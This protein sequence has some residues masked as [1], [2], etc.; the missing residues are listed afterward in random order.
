[1][2][3]IGLLDL[4]SVYQRPLVLLALIWGGGVFLLAYWLQTALQEN[5]NLSSE[6]IALGLAPLSEE[7]LKGFLLV[8]LAQNGRLSYSTEGTTYGFAIGTGFA[9]LENGLYITTHPEAALSVALS[10]VLSVSVMHASTT[11][12]L[13]TIV[14]TY[15]L[16]PTRLQRRWA[17]LA[18]ALASLIHGGFNFLALRLSG[19][20]VLLAGMGVG[21]LSLAAVVWQIRASVRLDSRSIRRELLDSL[22]SGELAAT[23]QPRHLA[24]HLEAEAPALG[25]E[26]MQRVYQYARLQAQRGLLRQSLLTAQHGTARPLLERDLARV[27]QQLDVLRRGMGLYTWLWLRSV[28]PS[29]EA[30]LWSHLAR[31]VEQE[32]PLLA[33][34]LKLNDRRARLSDQEVAE[35]VALLK[36]TAFFYPLGPE[37][38]EDVAILLHEAHY[39]LDELILG[40]GQVAEELYC[41]AAGNV[42][43]SLL[44][45]DGHQTILAAYERG[46]CFGDLSLIDRRPIEEAYRCLNAVRLYTFARADFLTLVYGKPQV[47]LEVMRKLVEDIRQQAALLAWFHQTSKPKIT[48]TISASPK[49]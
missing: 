35:R 16:Q 37:D 6:Q 31:E 11:A 33:L 7:A 29:S 18:W 4:Y 27:E 5:Q 21:L 34:L 30:E 20:A 2:Y 19:Q 47:G 26:R 38:L 17:L 24:D 49:N 10:R 40:P 1:L 43:A 48:A 13:G 14:G 22:S 42:V 23:L 32:Q 12:L 45:A 3:T 46:D 15:A 36:T 28:L 41:V 39:G 9:I 8:W 44:D 25:Q